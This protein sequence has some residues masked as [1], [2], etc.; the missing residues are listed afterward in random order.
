MDR[1]YFYSEI[2]Q[3]HLLTKSKYIIY[4]RNT[5]NHDVT[6]TLTKENLQI[7]KLPM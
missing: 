7:R 3:I 5:D 1:K 2:I 6:E 4:Y